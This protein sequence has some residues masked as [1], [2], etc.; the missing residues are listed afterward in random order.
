MIKLNLQY[1]AGEKTEKPTAK[2]RGDARKKG[3]VARS[4]EFGQAAV[5]L[6][7]LFTLKL[8]SGY[9]MNQL[10]HLFQV[11]FTSKLTYQLTDQSVIPLFIEMLLQLAKLILPIAG[12]VMVIGAFT[13]Y[14]QVG[15]LFTL[16]PLMPDFSKINPLSGFKRIFSMRTFVDLLKSILKMGAIGFI[17]YSEISK[18]WVRVSRLGDMDVSDMLSVVAS[19]AYGIFWKV[20]F[21]ML[22]LAVAD[23]LYQ[24][25]DFER[26]LKMSKQEV[27]EEYKQQEGS[28]EV[29]AKIKERQRAMA[30][31]R[32]MADVPKADVVITNPTH[33]AIALKYDS[34]SM[35]SPQVI[36]KGVDETAQRI[37]KIARE[38][39]VICVENRPLAQTLYRTVEIGESIPGDLFQAV[40][41]VL[42]YV[43]RLKG[44][45]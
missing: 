11:N 13:S 37:K 25:F 31:R 10:T 35:E 20:G 24:R 45:V 36:A 28:P 42:A 4:Q 44:K 2:K 7:G 19:L 38:S 41:E 17:V 43:Y 12:V 18:D 8:L 32:M 16:K 27:K 40:A 29:K 33:F 15:T 34:N 26:N 39:N 22:A 9:Y 5:L 6:S 21:A 23:F 14:L 30:M 1:F 3:Q